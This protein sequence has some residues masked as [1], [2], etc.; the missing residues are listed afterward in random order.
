VESAFPTIGIAGVLSA[1]GQNG[2]VLA[3][4]NTALVDV[5]T[6]NVNVRYILLVKAWELVNHVANCSNA[7]AYDLRAKHP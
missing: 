3:L 1:K 2:E 6:V 7:A 4:L 5:S